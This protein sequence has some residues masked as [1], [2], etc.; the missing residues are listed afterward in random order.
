MNDTLEQLASSLSRQIDRSGGRCVFVPTSGRPIAALDAIESHTFVAIGPLDTPS[1]SPQSQALFHIPSTGPAW[2]QFLRLTADLKTLQPGNDLVNGAKWDLGVKRTLVLWLTARL[3]IASVELRDDDIERVEWEP[4]SGIVAS[5]AGARIDYFPD[6]SFVGHLRLA[7]GTSQEFFFSGAASKVS[8]TAAFFPSLYNEDWLYALFAQRSGASLQLCGHAI[9]R[10]YDLLKT[11]SNAAFEEPGDVIGEGLLELHKN[12]EW[13]S[14]TSS[15]YWRMALL[16]RASELEQF[17][18][19]RPVEGVD[20]SRALAN[21]RAAQLRLSE[22]TPQ[23]LVAF[24]ERYER[25]LEVW[26]KLVGG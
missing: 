9:Q 22:L 23:R 17:A 21:L 18:R 7:S 20:W 6:Q 24:V 10:P 5:I 11:T 16:G 15:A 13:G 8:S 2:T 19:Q 12:N 1:A 14:R 25:D 26:R 3:G 4:D